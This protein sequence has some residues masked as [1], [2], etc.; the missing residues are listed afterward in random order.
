M[1]VEIIKAQPI[2]VGDRAGGKYPW[3][4]IDFGDV[5]VILG[6]AGVGSRV[7]DRNS[8]NERR[9]RPER[10]VSYKLPDGRA[11]IQRIA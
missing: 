3:E 10:F 8:R 4:S 1:T 7:H 9:G 6:S 2:R 11:G 5:F